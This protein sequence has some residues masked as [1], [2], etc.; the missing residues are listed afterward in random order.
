MCAVGTKNINGSWYIKAQNSYGSD[1]GDGGFVYVPRDYF[2]GGVP[3]W[4]IQVVTIPD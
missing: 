2:T 3:G 4:A 1:R